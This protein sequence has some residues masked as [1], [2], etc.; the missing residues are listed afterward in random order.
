M[1]IRTA[2]ITG[3][4]AGA[5]LITGC[6]ADTLPESAAASERAD[7][8]LARSL[9]IIEKEKTSV[10]S[11]MTEIIIDGVSVPGPQPGTGGDNLGVWADNPYEAVRLLQMADKAVTLEGREAGSPGLET[12]R[13]TV[14]KETWTELVREAWTSRMAALKTEGEA[15]MAQQLSRVPESKSEALK[16]ELASSFQTARLK[17]EQI[18]AT[19]E[20]EGVFI[21]KSRQSGA[22]P[23][24]LSIEN[25]MHYEENGRIKEE[26]VRT[27]YNFGRLPSD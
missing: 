13:V 20:A 15:V 6:P 17:L 5:A 21:I 16:R 7:R 2:L 10:S 3:I 22:R 11:T 19:L 18:T 27:V 26:V 12:M 25:R 8:L 14:S 4:V 9:S 23:E 24:Q 1:G